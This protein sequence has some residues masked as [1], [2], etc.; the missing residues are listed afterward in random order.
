LRQNIGNLFRCKITGIF[1]RPAVHHENQRR[2][3]PRIRLYR[4]PAWNVCD[5]LNCELASEQLVELWLQVR[6]RQFKQDALTFATAV[7]RHHKPW[8]FRR[9]AK[10][11][12]AETER[13]APVPQNTALLPAMLDLWPPDQGTVCK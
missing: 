7:K 4:Q 8:I 5:R 6:V 12:L 11:P 13:T 1:W 9:S 3:W 10:S 2:H